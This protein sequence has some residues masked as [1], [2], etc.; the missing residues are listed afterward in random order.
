MSCTW[1]EPHGSDC[2]RCAV[3]GACL[4]QVPAWESGGWK[5]TKRHDYDRTHALGDA[6]CMV[7]PCESAEQRDLEVQAAFRLVIGGFVARRLIA[8]LRWKGQCSDC[9]DPVGA[10]NEANY[11]DHR[12][13][14]PDH[15]LDG[16]P[17][18]GL[19]PAG[20]WY[21]TDEG[22]AWQ[23]DWPALAVITDYLTEHGMWSAVHGWRR[24]RARGVWDQALGRANLLTAARRRLVSI[25][26]VL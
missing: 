25:S 20:S 24:E 7:G 5:W 13:A 3:V 4:A 21:G 8:W 19:R 18:A 11:C 12:S 22:V 9:G 14:Y 15:P 26:A 10:M 17:V 2:A 23:S 6:E 1:P 16:T